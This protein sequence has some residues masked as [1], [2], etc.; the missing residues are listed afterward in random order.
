[1]SEVRAEIRR[2]LLPL[3]VSRDSLT[4]LEI[5]SNLAAA[6]GGEVSGLFIED[7]ELLTAGSLPF[8]RE[9][10]S[11]SG[12]SRRNPDGG[13]GRGPRCSGKGRLVRRRLT[14]A[15]QYVFGDSI[16][17]PHSRSDR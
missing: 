13:H 14:K 10:G 8:A 16:R 15:R 3:D 1:M 9:V 2:V 12:I 17:K 6:L 11:F 7:T 5:A 4:A